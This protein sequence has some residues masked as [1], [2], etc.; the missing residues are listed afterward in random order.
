MKKVILFFA[1]AVSFG[2]FFPGD[3]F[4]QG[5]KVSFE[6]IFREDSA[7]VNALALY[8]D[9]VRNSMLE[10]CRYPEILVKMEA[11]QKSIAAS[12]KEKM[13]PYPRD[14]QQKVWDI[15]RYP[16]LAEKLVNGGKKSNNEIE[17]ILENYPEEIHKTA[18]DYGRSHYDLLQQ[19]TELN[20]KSDAGFNEIVKPY[21]A[22]ARKAAQEMVK[23]PELASILTDN[24]K[25]AVMLGDAY[26]TEPQSIK[27]KLDS[28]NI[29]AVRQNAKNVEDWKNSLEKNPEA[30]KEFEESAKSY[31]KEQ[32]YSDET[33]VIHE[34]RIVT[35][36][37]CYPYPYWYG[38]PWWWDYPYWYP[39]PYWYDWGYYYGPYGIVYIGYPSF[40][41]IH[42]HFHYFPHHHHYPHFSEHCYNYYEGHRRVVSGMNGGI[43]H[44]VRESQGTL[45]A[46]FLNPDAGRV[47][48]FKELGKL[49]MDREKYNKENPGNTVSREKYYEEHAKTYPNIG[50]V[51]PKEE[52]PKPVVKPQ[53]PRVY[54]PVFPKTEPQYPK[55]QQPK[56]QPPKQPQPVQ[57]K[58]KPKTPDQPKKSGRGG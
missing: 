35:E 25:L 24:M 6:Q 34:T 10:V 33:L 31:A 15:V 54:P 42:W 41:F 29:E 40:H 48:R 55:P 8:P 32:G 19:I 38:S 37:I 57:P 4:G 28:L 56:V 53:E 12:F 3:V 58:P 51:P 49:E 20:R 22:S 9:S 7:T 36:Y 45:P 5:G 30:K 21:P 17:A 44:W 16:G 43:D 27:H 1:F 46:G 11:L 39:Y 2:I 47:T 14:E 23:Y 50:Q 52:R 13:T 18:Q 26:K